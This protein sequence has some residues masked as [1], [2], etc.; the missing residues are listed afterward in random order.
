VGAIPRLE[1]LVSQNLEIEFYK[2]TMTNDIDW[3]SMSDLKYSVRRYDKQATGK[4][5]HGPIVVELRN[6]TV[7]ANQ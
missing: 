3:R 1:Y 5:Y 6:L 7:L 2:D 4:A